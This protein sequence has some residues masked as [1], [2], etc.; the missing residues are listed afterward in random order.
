MILLREPRYITET[1]GKKREPGMEVGIPDST[2]DGVIED[3]VK[4]VC[5]SL[6]AFS[7]L[8]LCRQ[9]G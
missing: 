4:Y 2:G 1:S 9:V 8:R 6:Q 7:D 3:F 5:G